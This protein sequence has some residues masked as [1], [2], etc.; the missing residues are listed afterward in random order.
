M[1]SDCPPAGKLPGKGIITDPRDF[2]IR[3]QQPEPTSNQYC[4][5]CVFCI[6]IESIDDQIPFCSADETKGPPFEVPIGFLD[7]ERSIACMFF[8]SAG[9]RERVLVPSL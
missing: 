1:T 2:A 5:D 4:R 7:E 8:Q 6:Y 9:Q 3:H